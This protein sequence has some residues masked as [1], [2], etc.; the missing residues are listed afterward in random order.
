[1]VRCGAEFKLEGQNF[2][3]ISSSFIYNSN[4]PK[5]NAA[6]FIYYQRY[7]KKSV[8][9]TRSYIVVLVIGNFYLD[10]TSQITSSTDGVS[11]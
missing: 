4:D 7:Q 6:M 2:P 11:L 3:F 1:M 10:V 5:S 9:I 8:W